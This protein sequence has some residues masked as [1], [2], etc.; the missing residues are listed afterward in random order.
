[1]VYSRYAIYGSNHR[2]KTIPSCSSQSVRVGGRRDR[3]LHDACKTA[4]VNI[5]VPLS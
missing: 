4:V 1:M 5:G 3:V 2:D